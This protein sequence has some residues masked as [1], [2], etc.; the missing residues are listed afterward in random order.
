MTQHE[1]TDPGVFI[2][3]SLTFDN[4]RDQR[5]EGQLISNILHLNNIRSD[6]YYIR[7]KREFIEVLDLFYQSNFRY[8]HLS[9]H[10]DKQNIHLTLDTIPY[11]ELGKLLETHLF[12]KRLFLSACEAANA[13]LAKEII[14]PTGCYSVIGPVKKIEFRD[15]AITWAA[16]YHLMFRNNAKSMFRKDLIRNLQKTVNTF[17]QPLNY[18][19]TSRKS[20]T[21]IKKR[22]IHVQQVKPGTTDGEEF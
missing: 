10:G 6:Y 7:T 14:K 11:K 21:G 3:E 2:I 4:E 9:C 19:S 15:A 17:E 1:L 18:F 8:L 16:F 5:C 12:K 13:D 20:K 22:A